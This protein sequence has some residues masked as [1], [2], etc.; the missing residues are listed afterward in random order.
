MLQYFINIKVY[1]FI[2]GTCEMCGSDSSSLRDARVAGTEMK[3]CANCSKHGNIVEDRTA[4]SRTFY[5]K[6]RGE[7]IEFDVVE[8]Y[9][10][11]INSELS[12]RN[13][14]SH[15]LA[16][17]VNIKESSLHK[18]LSNKIKIDVLSAKKIETFL[19]ITLTRQVESVNVSDY[20]EEE[21]QEDTSSSLGDLLMKQLKEKNNK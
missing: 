6:R 14:N 3:L 18:Y 4:V 5:K 2:M 11:L 8:N 1:N 9:A 7:E 12:K 16:R 21:I 19:E 10:S 17:A 20:I 15:Q 13:L